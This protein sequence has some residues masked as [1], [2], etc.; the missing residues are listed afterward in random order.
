[1]KKSIVF[2]LFAC[3]LLALC[4]CVSTD[5][6]REEK[7][8]KLPE[9][10][11]E[12]FKWEY[13]DEEKTG[14]RITEYVGTADTVVIPEQIEGLPVVVIL[15]TRDENNLLTK[16]AFEGSAI[17]AAVIP[18]TVRSIWGFAGC[19]ELTTVLVRENSELSYIDGFQEC[20]ALESLD[21]SHTKLEAVS[22]FEGCTAL[23]Q[24]KLPDS[25][26]RIA[27][28]A[29]YNCTA[30]EAIDLPNDLERIDREAFGNCTSLKCI[31]VPAKLNLVNGMDVIPFHT[32]SSLEEIVFE[33]GREKL[34]GYAFFEIK[35][36]AKI[37]I[38]ASVREFDSSAFFACAPYE[39]VF[40]GDFPTLG[41]KKDF[42]GTPTI[43]YDPQ[44][45]GWE[46]CPWKESYTVMPLK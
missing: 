38:P 1:M 36:N 2:V 4:S 39:I 44:A 6:I 29:F 9:N 23:N 27:E 18:K 45:E 37:I 16:G 46:Q 34:S 43:Y 33:E 22:G 42:Y 28:R 3:L 35:T 26:K 40:K 19:K 17:E 8:L 11:V 32:L 14:I 31:T 25:V 41:G 21:L 7:L 13:S 15:G 12:D 10:P 24:I 20:T 5:S 30:L